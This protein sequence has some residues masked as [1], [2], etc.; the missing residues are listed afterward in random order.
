MQE[1]IIAFDFGLKNIGIAVGQRL[2]GSASEL[3]PL[4]AKEGQPQWEK[5]QVLLQEWQPSRL[6]VGLPLNMD[7]TPTSIT[8]RVKKFSQRLHGRFG[9]P[10]EL[11]DERLTT[12]EAK[13]EA[14]ERGHHGHYASQPVDS[15]AAR[16][17]LESWFRENKS[18]QSLC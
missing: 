4:P 1:T 6:V 8:P 5:V 10:V 17:I 2:I 7:G 3:P 12:C 15:I 18:A 14:H 11:M 16:L 13:S 9:L